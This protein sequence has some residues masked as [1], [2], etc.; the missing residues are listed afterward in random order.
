VVCVRSG[1]WLLRFVGGV[2]VGAEGREVERR[3][4]CGFKT[5][6]GDFFGGW[7]SFFSLR[8]F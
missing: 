3:S 4:G 7:F 5:R 2:G 8:F 1:V 6:G